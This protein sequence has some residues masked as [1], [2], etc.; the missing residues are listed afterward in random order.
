LGIGALMA[1]MGWYRLHGDAERA[2]EAF[3]S[4]GVCVGELQRIVDALVAWHLQG[5]SSADFAYD[6][7][8]RKWDLFYPFLSLV[9]SSDRSKANEFAQ[10]LLRPDVFREPETQDA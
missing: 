10:L 1:G 5:L 9:L 4:A 6:G 2:D 7:T 3:R 8:L